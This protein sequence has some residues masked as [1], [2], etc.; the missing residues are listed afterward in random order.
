MCV[1][2]VYYFLKLSIGERLRGIERTKR[3]INKRYRK[4]ERP[5]KRD[6]EE[7]SSFDQAIAER[8]IA[9]K[10]AKRQTERRFPTSL[11]QRNIGYRQGCKTKLI[12]IKV[13]GERKM[14]MKGVREPIELSNQGI[15]KFKY[16][17]R[18]I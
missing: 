3:E 1:Y 9:K 8:E 10:I 17:H 13:N 5:G 16:K 14:N 2:T 12:E 11:S 7:Y 15:A 18:N 6:K 4:R